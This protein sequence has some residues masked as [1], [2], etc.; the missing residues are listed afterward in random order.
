MHSNQVRIFLATAKANLNMS[1]P[2]VLAWFYDSLSLAGTLW[3]CL[4]IEKT[5]FYPMVLLIIIPFLNG[6]FIGN[7]NPTF[8]SPNPYGIKPPCSPE[9]V[10]VLL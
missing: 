9:A 3:V 2:H 8:S 10:P 4:K 1:T 7:I 5:P 6:Y